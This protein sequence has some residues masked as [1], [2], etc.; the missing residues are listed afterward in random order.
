MP[1]APITPSCP[2]GTML[3]KHSEAM[4]ITFVTQVSRQAT[5]AFS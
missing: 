1:M 3:E 4:P 2:T 5:P